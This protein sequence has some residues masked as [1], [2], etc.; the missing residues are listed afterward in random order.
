MICDNCKKETDYFTT[1]SK[2][3]QISPE[4]Y[5]LDEFDWCL[6]CVMNEAKKKLE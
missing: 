5:I 4:F 1:I 6:Q 2:W 3:R